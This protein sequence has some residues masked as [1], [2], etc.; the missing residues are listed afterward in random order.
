MSEGA[1]IVGKNGDSDKPPRIVI[2]PDFDGGREI[3]T[4]RPV[5]RQG[6]VPPPATQGQ[7]VQ[8]RPSALR[9]GPNAANTVTPQAFAGP[10]PTPSPT[11][12][13]TPLAVASAPAPAQAKKC[14][15]VTF[16]REGRDGRPGDVVE[17]V[18]HEVVVHEDG[19][20][21]TLVYDHEGGSQFVYRPA[22][23]DEALAVCVH[24]EDKQ[25]DRIF[26]CFATGYRL[27]HGRYEYQAL[28]VGDGALVEGR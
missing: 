2:D 12:T 27:R 9:S 22:F 26:L 3:T 15:R 13:P 7:P 6:P 14:V 10:P 28:T 24:G 23:T 18:F 20:F 17:A 16:E 21:L 1:Y 4:S 19:L 25:P 11:P 5:V 8:D